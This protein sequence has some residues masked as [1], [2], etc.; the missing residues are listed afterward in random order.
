MPRYYFHVRRGQV[1]IL[2]REGA[3]LPDNAEAEI[4]ALRR[5]EQIVR[6]EAL[7]GVP[8]RSGAIIV[9]DDWRTVFELPF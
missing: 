9:A 4:E 1:T 2:D 3:E 8:G 7:K 5:A 6:G